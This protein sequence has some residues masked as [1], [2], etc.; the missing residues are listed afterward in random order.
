MILDPELYLQY[1]E[2][3]NEASQ[4]Y[5]DDIISILEDDDKFSSN[6]L[7]DIEKAFQDKKIGFFHNS[8]SIIN[9]HG[10]TIKSHIGRRGVFKVLNHEKE[11][12]LRM[13][14]L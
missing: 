9:L 7:M 5:K 4:K 10:N 13:I 3:T 12:N 8:I 14:F 11:E 1:D 6:K 2:F